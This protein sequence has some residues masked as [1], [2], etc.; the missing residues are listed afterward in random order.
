MAWFIDL[1]YILV[2]DRCNCVVIWL[3]IVIRIGNCNVCN[4]NVFVPV[5]V[6]MTYTNEIGHAM[7]PYCRHMNDHDCCYMCAIIMPL[8]WKIF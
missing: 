8:S 7:C 4:S 3:R 5:V 1:D 6:G 2:I